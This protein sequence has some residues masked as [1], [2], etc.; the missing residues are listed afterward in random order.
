MITCGVTETAASEA[1][2]A[3]EA[4]DEVAPLSLEDSPLVSPLAVEGVEPDAVEG[5][6]RIIIVG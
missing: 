1:G 3:V 5:T 6:M 4:V 2:A